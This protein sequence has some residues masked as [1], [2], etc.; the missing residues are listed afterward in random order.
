MNYYIIEENNEGTK[1]QPIVK[2]TIG[3]FVKEV[4][5]YEGRLQDH[6]MKKYKDISDDALMEEVYL[7][8]KNVTDANRQRF[9]DLSDVMKGR[10]LCGK[11]FCEF[12]EWYSRMFE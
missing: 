4:D 3:D 9:F 11:P 1:S 8:G 12:T 2:H 6:K 10:G 5:R 7:L